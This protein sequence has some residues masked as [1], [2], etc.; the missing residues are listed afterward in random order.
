VVS[1]GDP[2]EFA[3][4]AD[5]VAIFAIHGQERPGGREGNS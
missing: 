4:A 2:D 1:R 5:R 3:A